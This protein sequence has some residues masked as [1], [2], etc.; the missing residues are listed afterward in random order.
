[1]AFWAESRRRN[2]GRHPQRITPDEAAIRVLAEAILEE[3]VEAVALRARPGGWQPV[4]RAIAP[5]LKHL[6]YQRAGDALIVAVDSNGSPVHQPVHET[7]DQPPEEC[8]LCTL[9]RRIEEIQ[10][11]VQPVAGHL[12]IQTAVA[13]AV[14]AI[15]AWY[16]FGIDPDC[17]EAGWIQKQQ[18]GADAP[19]EIRR[20]KQ[21][22]Y[23]TDRPSLQR[24]RE[25]AEHHARRL[26]DDLE[27][28]SAYFP[29]TFG[30]FEK[31][32]RNWM[33]E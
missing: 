10:N 21:I 25:Q 32:L 18:A 9:R 3:E 1:M 22:V 4:V 28:L 2:E 8:R 5:T 31:Q 26:A 24:E 30:H 7:A 6:H 29:N 11:E 27:T 20:L 19:V 16:Q 33:K 17:T 12:P 13:V 15:E 14:P 23:G